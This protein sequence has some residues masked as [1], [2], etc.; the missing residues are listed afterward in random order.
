MRRVYVLLAMIFIS[1]NVFS[2]ELESHL[3]FLE[4][5][6]GKNWMGGFTGDDAPPFRISLLFEPILDGRVVKYSRE[7]KDADFASV[8]QFYWDPKNVEV[9][10]LSLNN[11]GIVEEGTVRI[12]GDKVVLQGNSYR[13]DVTI[14]F[15]TILSIDAQGTLRDTFLRKQDG[16]WTQGHIQEFVAQ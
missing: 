16:E 12:D 11:R 15:K 9:R 5:F 13:S 4:P 7:V 3:Q 14:E 10:F 1:S 6:L 8:T 2:S